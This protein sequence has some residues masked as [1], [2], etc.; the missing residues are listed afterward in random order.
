MFV[1]IAALLFGAG[2][3]L[4][5]A[6]RAM[7]LQAGGRLARVLALHRSAEGRAAPARPAR[8]GL[9]DGLEANARQ[10][11]LNV[12]V[13]H[14]AWIAAL[15]GGGVGLLIWLITGQVWAA[16][17]GATAGLA[18]P[19]TWLAWRRTQQQD[20]YRTQIDGALLRL[21][22][23]LRAGQSLTQGIAALAEQVKPP[24]GREFHRALQASR[25]NLSVPEALALLGDRIALP[26]YEEFVLAVRLHAEAGGNLAETLERIAEQVRGR[27]RVR[28]AIQAATSGSRVEALIV[29]ATTVSMAALVPVVAPGLLDQLLQDPAGRLMGLAA[30]V[31][32]AAAWVIVSKCLEVPYE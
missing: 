5:F 13:R 4:T 7:V 23:H 19:R 12:S 26:E 15:A 32:T 20:A 17:A 24:L 29:Q 21:A 16:T 25:L 9:W 3:A 2:I 22:N 8:P 14:L 27:R 18:A 10:A 28:A 6:L 1:L 30:L 11:G 31:L